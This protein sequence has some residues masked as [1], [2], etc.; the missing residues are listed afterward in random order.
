MP[1]ITFTRNLRKAGLPRPT[2]PS[3]SSSSP[4]SSNPK[5]WP[6]TANYWAGTTGGELTDLVRRHAVAPGSD[7]PRYLPFADPPNSTPPIKPF[8]SGGRSDEDKHPS[9]VT[10]RLLLRRLIRVPGRPRWAFREHRD[11]RTAVP[12]CS[13]LRARPPLPPSP[14]RSSSKKPS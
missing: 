7:M 2:H 4:P 1:G 13:F 6:I 10:F 8:E 14:H 12:G 5:N 11:P 9:Q 3:T